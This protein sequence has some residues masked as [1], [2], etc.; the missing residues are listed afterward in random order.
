EIRKY[1]EFTEILI[2]KL[3]FQR[4]VPEIPHSRRISD[5]RAP[6]WWRFRERRR[7]TWSD[8]LRTLTFVRFTR[9]GLLLCPRISSWLGE[10][11]ASV[12]KLSFTVSNPIELGFC[13]GLDCDDFS[14]CSRDMCEFV[15]L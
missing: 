3:P 4:L 7:P 6:S 9:R 13:F 1:Q 5:S 14:I 8:C 2:R 10:L 15:L 12:L 11:G